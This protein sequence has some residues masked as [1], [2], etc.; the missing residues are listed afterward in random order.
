[1]SQLQLPGIDRLPRKPRRVMA[2]L[3][4]AG[5]SG[6]KDGTIARYVCKRGW[7][8]GWIK[9]DRSN[10]DMWRGVPCEVCNA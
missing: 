3:A 8:S 1:M 7:D 5:W 4:D 10:S 2:K 9:D 6:Y